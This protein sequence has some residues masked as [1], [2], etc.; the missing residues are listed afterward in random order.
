MSTELRGYLENIRAQL[1]LA[2]SSEK[3]ILGEIYTHFEERVIELREAGLSE[4]EA[5]EEAARCFGSAKAIAGE[6][7]RV[8]TKSNWAQAIIAAVPHFLFA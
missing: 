7:N 4:E 5:V 2:P 1:R 6:M 8:H 3:E